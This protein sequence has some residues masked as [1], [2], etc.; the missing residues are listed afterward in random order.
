MTPIFSHD[1]ALST[2]PIDYLLYEYLYN[3][4]VS[5]EFTDVLAFID[6]TKRG[7]AVVHAEVQM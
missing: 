4:R 5:P 2:L 7:A 1:C 3:G 6:L